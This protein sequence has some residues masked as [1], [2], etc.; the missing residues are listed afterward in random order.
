MRRA[1]TVIFPF[2]PLPEAPP[3]SAR[4][5][6]FY[7]VPTAGQDFV[8]IGLV[9]DVSY[10]FVIRGIEDVV[11][12]NGQFDH[13]ETCPQVA[14]GNGNCVNCLGT[15]FICNLLKVPRVNPA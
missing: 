2:A 8:W 10:Q 4:P 5:Q 15:Q 11:Q 3:T 9:A 1:E 6:F 7:A 12:S 13:A 14:A